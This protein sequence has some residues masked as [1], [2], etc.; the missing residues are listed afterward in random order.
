VRE[1]A[2]ALGKLP[3]DDRTWR[4]DYGKPMSAYEYYGHR[5]PV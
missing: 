5:D 4:V 3:P 1:M 2:R